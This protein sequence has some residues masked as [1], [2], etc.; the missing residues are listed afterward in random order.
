M[1][2]DTEKFLQVLE[3][4]IRSFRCAPL[5]L[6][7]DNM[8]AAL[9]KADKYDPEINPKLAEF[10][11]HYSMSV[12]PCHPNTP[13]HKGKVENAGAG[14]VQTLGQAGVGA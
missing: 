1:R 3:N 14:R 11:R 10:C 7:V 13:Q 6:S 4:A 2:Q 8:K 12:M 9:T 5:T